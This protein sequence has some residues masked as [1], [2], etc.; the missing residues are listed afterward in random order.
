M[1]EKPNYSPFIVLVIALLAGFTAWMVIRLI[2]A[3]A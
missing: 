2:D 1:R 3:C